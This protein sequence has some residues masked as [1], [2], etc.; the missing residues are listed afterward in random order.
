M[1]YHAIQL[2]V[3]FDIQQ[4]VLSQNFTKKMVCVCVS[5]DYGRLESVTLVEKH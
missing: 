5:Q 1:L 3:P 2:L 4:F